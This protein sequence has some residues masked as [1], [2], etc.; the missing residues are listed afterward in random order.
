MLGMVVGSTF[1]EKVALGCIAD[2]VEASTE[3]VCTADH[4]DV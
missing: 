3:A 4:A 2:S 1:H